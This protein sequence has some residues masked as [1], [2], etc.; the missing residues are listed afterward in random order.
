M[1]P[2]TFVNRVRSAIIEENISTYKNFF[3]STSLDDATDPY[4]KRALVFYQ[5]H[6]ESDR[7]VLLEIVRQVMDDTVSNVFAVLDGVSSLDG[8]PED[9]DLI[10]KSN[11]Q[12]INGSLQDLFLEADER[13][14]Q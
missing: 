2:E 10:A 9:F 12:Q 4:W 5:S 1:N 13:E 14:R 7:T 11:G 8:S 3:E 6:N